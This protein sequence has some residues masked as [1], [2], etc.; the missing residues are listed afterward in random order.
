MPESKYV[1]MICRLAERPQVEIVLPQGFQVAS[2][3][4]ADED[5]LYRCYYAALEAGDA[6]F[7]H[8]QSKAERR[9]YFD[10]LRLEEARNESGSSVILKD[11]D[12]V[13]FTYVIP[14]GKG[15]CHISCMCVHPD[16]WRQGLGTFM[17]L[18][19][20]KNVAAQ[21]YRS[22]TLG[23]GTTMGAFQLYRRYGFE[24]IEEAR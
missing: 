24:A 4:D 6:R 18:H 8:H 9:E 2:L 16:H 20:M 22:I 14:Y 10:T 7:F 21:G 19:A 3:K 23:T 17:L 5:A 13:G 11:G 15:N 1:E 12:I